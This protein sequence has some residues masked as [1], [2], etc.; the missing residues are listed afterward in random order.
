[1]QGARSVGGGHA[2]EV[3][4]THAGRVLE[5]EAEKPIEADVRRPNQRKRDQTACD[6][7]AEKQ[8]N[9]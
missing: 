6:R 1:M 8:A 4:F 9:R 7:S 2:P 5:A 3:R